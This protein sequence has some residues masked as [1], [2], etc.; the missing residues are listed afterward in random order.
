MASKYNPDGY[1]GDLLI[2][3]HLYTYAG[4]DE[5]DLPTLRKAVAQGDLAVESIVENAISKVGNIARVNTKGMDFAD[6]S[7]AKKVVVCNN[8]TIAKPNR[9]ADV[10]TK[11]K[12]GILRV[13][14]ADALSNELFFF[15]IPPDFYVGRGRRSLGLRINFD[16]SGGHPV[17]R[18]V[19]GPTFDLWFV[20]RVKTFEALCS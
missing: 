1:K 5:Q 16:N 10:S 4:Y 17:L 15:K 14:V 18:K 8:G 3:E 9:S 7:D 20:Y 2:V 13:V 19:E 11:N 6:G 12:T